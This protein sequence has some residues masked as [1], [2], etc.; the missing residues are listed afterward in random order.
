MMWKHRGI[1]YI[2]VH[3]GVPNTLAPCASCSVLLDSNGCTYGGTE[4]TPNIVGSKRFTSWAIHPSGSI[5]MQRAS[6]PWLSDTFPA[7]DSRVLLGPSRLGVVAAQDN[8][9][10]FEQTQKSTTQALKSQSWSPLRV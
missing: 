6:L 8:V 3:H 4:F 2:G 5:V 7:R 9:C 10:G 1:C